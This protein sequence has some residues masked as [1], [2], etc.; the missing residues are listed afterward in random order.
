MPGHSLK[1]IVAHISYVMW[2]CTVYPAAGSSSS[3]NEEEFQ[4]IVYTYICIETLTGRGR[5][6]DQKQPLVTDPGFSF[7]SVGGKLKASQLPKLSL[8]YEKQ[9]HNK[10]EISG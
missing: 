7:L 5:E 2:V 6:D 10:S 3:W 1:R 8:N 4:G 9:L